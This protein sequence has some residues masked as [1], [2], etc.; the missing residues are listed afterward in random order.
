MDT[1]EIYHR[2]DQKESK[3]EL[4]FC[5]FMEKWVLTIVN[6]ILFIVGIAQ[7]G[8]GIYMI[9]S[10]ATTWTGAGLSNFVIGMGVCVT[11][12][13]F[14]GCCGACKENKCMLWTY[15][16]LLFWIILG[17]T[18][19]LTVCAIGETYTEDFLNS[20]WNSLSV[21]DQQKI[22]DAYDCCSFNGNSTDATIEDQA[23]YTLCVSEHPT[24]V[25]SCW[26]K[27]NGEVSANLKSVTIVG[28]IVVVS[29]VLFLFMT[30]ALINGISLANVNRRMSYA[31]RN[32]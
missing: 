28:A 32:I 9:S 10:N 31:F 23:D 30:M 6:S 12:I 27:V 20:C 7:I 22:E 13:A 8:C 2:M 4:G 1:M 15:A 17:Q 18:V 3:P 29:Q 26:D 16:F 14:L 24:Y 25:Q 5:S 11:F 21:T 19:G